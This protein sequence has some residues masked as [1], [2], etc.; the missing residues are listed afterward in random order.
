MFEIANR[1][2]GRGHEV[3]ITTLD[4][5]ANCRWFP[6][7][8]QVVGL[9]VLTRPRPLRAMSKVL[10]IASHD[11]IVRHRDWRLNARDNYIEL[12]ARRMP[13]CDANI[14]TYCLTAFSVFRSGKGVPFYHMQHYEPFFFDDPYL[15]KLAE[16][17]YSLPMHKIVNSMWLQKLMRQKYGIE[18]PRVTHGTFNLDLFSRTRFRGTKAARRVVAM[19]KDTPWKG[20]HDLLDA[21]RIVFQERRDVDL[22]LYGSGIKTMSDVPYTYVHNPTDDQLGQ[23]Y[24]SADVMVM[25]SWYESFPNPPLEAMACGVP[26]VTTRDGT[27]EFAIDQKTALVVPPRN[28]QAMA[29]AILRVLSDEQ[30]RLTL[31]MNG[32]NMANKFDWDT[33]TN[34]LEA[35][36]QE[37]LRSDERRF[38]A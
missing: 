15:V 34:Q 16:E 38:R 4:N 23:L 36:L 28:P 24:S 19:G 21:M 18:L 30:L 35:I 27:E 2:V 3:T 7:K 10:R 26:V 37:K 33:T 25:P 1:L 29:R 22:F 11:L 32:P 9:D 20:L 17:S 31:S 8:A 13:E 6:L 12:L 5:E 14:A